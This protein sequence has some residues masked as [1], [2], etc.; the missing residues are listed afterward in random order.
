MKCTAKRPATK[1]NFRDLD[2]PDAYHI[3]LYPQDR[4]YVW[5]ECPHCGCVIGKTREK[6]A[7]KELSGVGK[8]FS[9]KTAAIS[10]QQAAGRPQPSA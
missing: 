3:N 8:R 4:R 5:Y 7:K 6:R 2:H 10:H 9:A 1:A